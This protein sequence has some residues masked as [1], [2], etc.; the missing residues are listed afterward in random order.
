VAEPDL[1]LQELIWATRKLRAKYQ[2]DRHRPRYHF[3]TPEGL[4]HPFDPNGAIFWRGRYHLFYIVQVE[5]HGHCWGHASSIDLLHWRIHPIALVPGDGDEGIFSGCA[6]LDKG[7]IPTIVYLGVKT[8]ICI[9]KSTDE[10]LIHWEKDPANPVIP[11]PREGTREYTQYIVHDPHVWLEGETY[12]AILNGRWNIAE[13]KGDTAYLLKSSDLIHWEYLWPFYEPNP[14]WTGPEEDCACPDFFRLGG[15]HVLLCISHYA[16]ARYYL[17]RYENE[18]FHPER[19]VR[20]NWP[21][22][23][24]FAPESLLDGS[25]RRIF[26]GWVCGGRSKE[27]QEA[28]GWSGVM[29]LPRVLS[30]EEHGTVRI[31]PVQELERLRINP[32]SKQNIELDDGVPV[33]L[34]AMGTAFELALDIAP[35]SAAQVGIRVCCSPDGT[36]GTEIAFD[37]AAG[38]LSIDWS[39]SSLSP[40][41]LWPWPHPH[42][43]EKQPYADRVQTAPFSLGSGET[44]KLRIYLD[45]SILEVFAN[46]RQC[47]TQRIYPTREDSTGV[48]LFARGGSAQV[49]T[50]EAWE[51]A[52]ANPW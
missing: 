5:G 34:E 31:E 7:G 27:V 1:H 36:E 40:E 20:M 18:K 33:P 3:V 45:G 23:T 42:R 12:Y 21:G 49:R 41:V 26:W 38:T 50:L 51:M 10:D 28:A 13:K 32:V 8:G 19:H 24:M 48:V 25:G 4:C 43:R 35:G 22:G 9:A 14:A 11:I 2:Q 16:G 52:A 47:I 44:L 46:R 29:S 37:P 17:G 15:K 6:L 30:L 39:K